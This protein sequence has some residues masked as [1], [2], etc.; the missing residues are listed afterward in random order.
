MLSPSLSAGDT[1]Y[2]DTDNEDNARSGSSDDDI[3]RILSDTSLNYPIEFNIN[4]TGSLPS[5][6]AQ[7]LINAHDID[8]ELGQEVSIS[9]NG[10]DLG[11][12]SGVADEDSTNIFNV[13]IGQ[14]VSGNNIVEVT[15]ANPWAT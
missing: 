8:E 9:I 2:T 13:P 12:L 11:D 7:L 15:I 14:I 1:Y 3:G 5:T 6:S 10:N 4:L